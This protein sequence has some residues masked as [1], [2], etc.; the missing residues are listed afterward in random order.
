MSHRYT[1][2]ALS[3]LDELV[4]LDRY[5]RASDR[6]PGD[7]FEVAAGNVCL[8]ELLMSRFLEDFLDLGQEMARN[9]R[10][11]LALHLETGDGASRFTP[12]GFIAAVSGG[13]TAPVNVPEAVKRFALPRW[14]HLLFLPL[15]LVSGNVRAQLLD[16]NL[17]PGDSQG[18]VTMRWRAQTNA[19]EIRL[20]FETAGVEIRGIADILG[21]F[22]VDISELVVTILL[23]PSLAARRLLWSLDASADVK[24]GNVSPPAAAAFVDTSLISRQIEK[25]FSSTLEDLLKD[26][27][28]IVAGLLGAIPLHPVPESPAGLSDP[29]LVATFNLAGLEVPARLQDAD[30][31]Q[32]FAALILDALNQSIYAAGLLPS[33]VRHVFPSLG[34]FVNGGADMAQTGDVELFAR[35]HLEA[36]HMVNRTDSFSSVTV[37]SGGGGSGDVLAVEHDPLP[38]VPDAPGIECMRYLVALD[39]ISFENLQAAGFA[40]FECSIGVWHPLLADDDQV[41]AADE[42]A[43]LARVDTRAPIVLGRAGLNRSAICFLEWG[44][45]LRL[46][47]KVEAATLG[48][49]TEFIHDIEMSEGQFTALG[50]FSPEEPGHPGS[51]KFTV[52]YR[53][54]QL[55][56]ARAYDWI[57]V[58][59][60]DVRLSAPPLS[61][62]P[63]G[64]ALL[65]EAYVNAGDI[66]TMIPFR[67][68][69]LDQP[70]AR[71]VL[72]DWDYDVIYPEDRIGAE[73][74]LEVRAIRL[75]PVN[76]QEIDRFVAPRVIHRFSNAQ[77]D[78]ITGDDLI[79]AA[80]NGAVA[81]W[82]IPAGLPATAFVM[83][84]ESNQLQ[85]TVTLRNQR[86]ELGSAPP[87]F[88]PK[89]FDVEFPMVHVEND[90]DHGLSGEGEL[91][92]SCSVEVRA[93]D[94]PG[95]D[96]LPSVWSGDTR[97]LRASDPIDLDLPGPPTARGVYARPNDELVFRVSGQDLDWPP[98]D[99]HDRMGTARISVT[100]PEDDRID[101]RN[102]GVLEQQSSTN[103]FVAHVRVITTSIPPA[104]R[105]TF[106]G[107]EPDVT[108]ISVAPGV[109][110]TLAYDGLVSWATSG[111]LARSIDGETWEEQA[112]VDT[113]DPADSFDVA[114][115]QTTHYRLEVSNV[116]GTNHS[117]TLIV[118]VL[119]A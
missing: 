108:D 27:V 119:N 99:P 54:Q 40:R 30:R 65:L 74:S 36:A 44:G 100:V 29:Q 17:R 45:K 47:G 79:E 48:G 2:R 107:L 93:S 112:S 118:T 4:V 95:G 81:E 97:V 12:S 1:R 61:F 114:P 89:T 84:D 113:T 33:N 19:L 39:A 85:A 31:T 68:R 3:I 69:R 46:A 88:A 41:V 15:A 14:S 8:L 115:V 52:H 106:E 73:L 101:F 102:A 32:L 16:V 78:A 25:H 21:A 42:V 59:F 72:D 117:P 103:D 116:A 50:E 67:S 64:S 77:E 34:E 90:T 92:F 20:R 94:L 83:A 98:A 96:S 60:N 82:G 55:P 9:G 110:V 38:G 91:R 43:E 18:D 7:E 62:L 86:Y 87:L 57:Q 109:S 70:L 56:Y 10:R 24:T 11:P 6:P 13:T 26:H 76:G 35:R 5:Q 111:R 58:T 80:N 63:Q 66:G 51:S 53:L 28:P 37:E 105:C 71:I 75:N 49:T 22:R 23:H 104:P